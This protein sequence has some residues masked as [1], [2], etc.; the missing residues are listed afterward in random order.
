MHIVHDKI[1]YAIFKSLFGFIIFY[2]RL[3]I[4]GGVLDTVKAG[5]KLVIVDDGGINVLA[6]SMLEI[7]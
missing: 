4:W 7:I 2:L 1:I 5:Q 3:E 6:L